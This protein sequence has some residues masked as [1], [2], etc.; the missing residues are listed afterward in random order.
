M[1]MVCSGLPLLP[2]ARERRSRRPGTATANH[3]QLRQTTANGLGGELEGGLS[4][5][6]G[7]NF[8]EWLE[9]VRHSLCELRRTRCARWLDAGLPEGREWAG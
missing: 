4:T 1:A 2:E 7:A 5:R 3:C 6:M 8:C 9:G